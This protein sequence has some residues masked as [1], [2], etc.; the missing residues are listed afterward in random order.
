MWF[1]NGTEDD[2]MKNQHHENESHGEKERPFLRLGTENIFLS[3]P[4]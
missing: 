3:W 4:S 2:S 1:I